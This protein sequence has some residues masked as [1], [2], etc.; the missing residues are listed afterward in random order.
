MKDVKGTTR[1]C[2]IIGNPVG[3]SVSPV[4]QNTLADITGTELVYVPFK[5][6]DNIKAA[7]EGA[8]A[9]NVFGLNVTVPHKSAV[10]ECLADIDPIA[11]SIGAVNT[12]VRTDRGYKGYNTDILG[13]KREL[14]EAGIALGG[15]RVIILGAGGAARAIAFLCAKENASAIYILNRTVSKAENIAASV[16]EY[17]EAD[18]AKAMDIADYAGLE[19][20]GYVCIQT[21][22]VGLYP[23]TDKAPVEDKA[24]YKKID[25]AVDIIYNPAVTK[26]MKLV[27]ASGK[28][29]D[30]TDKKAYNGLKMLLYQGVSAYEL[31]NNVQISTQQSEEVY[32]AMCR[33]MGI[34]E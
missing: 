19:G 23:D 17:F 26:F 6:E 21:T 14:G 3:H 9:L 5:V 16:N 15:R 4:L 18:I 29:S 32:K 2:G 10:I 22:S 20:G 1:V 34:D 7:I 8:Y 13:L 24:F 27:K 12:L 25:A 11:A 30:G 28:A 31:W 33:E